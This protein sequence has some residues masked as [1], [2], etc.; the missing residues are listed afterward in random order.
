MDNQQGPSVYM[1]NSVQC[2]VAAWM[3]EEFGG[4]WIHVY[5][6]RSP[7]L[8]CSPHNRPMNLRDERLRQA[9]LR[10]PADQEVGT[11]DLKIL[12]GPGCQVLLWIGDGGGEETQ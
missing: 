1:E 7:S 2:Y 6:L 10:E 4:E 8:L 3:G 9:R 5:V 11:L 12:S